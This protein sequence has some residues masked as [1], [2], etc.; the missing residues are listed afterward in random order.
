MQR[1]LG[2][3]LRRCN[4]CRLE[5]ACGGWAH[6][7]TPHFAI[8]GRGASRGRGAKAALTPKGCEALTPAPIPGC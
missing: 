4:V 1:R 5:K 2:C 7:P 3:E 8:A 6:E